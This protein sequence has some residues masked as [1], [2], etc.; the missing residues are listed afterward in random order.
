MGKSQDKARMAIFSKA[1]SALFCGKWISN[2][3]SWFYQSGI[4]RI[5]SNVQLR[6]RNCY[7][8]I[9]PDIESLL[10][11]EEEGKGDGK[12]DGG[13]DGVGESMTS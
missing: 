10:D 11:H 7:R 1:Q 2:V 4:S 12:E 5:Y 3:L 13:A 8:E 6:L 9:H